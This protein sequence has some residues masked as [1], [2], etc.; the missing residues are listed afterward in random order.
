MPFGNGFGASHTP[1][2]VAQDAAFGRLC[3]RIDQ[4]YARKWQADR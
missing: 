1:Q 2:D 3:A 4:P